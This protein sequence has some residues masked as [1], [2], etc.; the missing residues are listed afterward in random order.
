MTIESTSQPPKFCEYSCG[1]CDQVSHTSD[2]SDGLF[3]YSSNPENIAATIEETVKKVSETLSGQKWKTWKDLGVTG[4]IIFCEICKSIRH[5]KVVVADVTTLNFNLLFEI[6]FSLGLNKPVIPIRDTSYIRDK[7]VF[8]DLGLLDT[9]GYLDFQNSDELTKGICGNTNRPPSFSQY[10]T[11]NSEQPIYLIKSHIYTDG[12]IRLLSS[13][14]KSGLRFRTFDP[15]ETSRLSLHEAF[16]Q[17]CS[18]YGVVAHLVDPN[19][20]GAI[21]HNA[22]CAFLSGMAMATGKS[23]LMLQESE[24]SQPIDYRDVVKYYTQPSSIPDLLVPFVKSIVEKFQETRFIATSLPL[25]QLEKVDLGDLSAENEIQALGNY[26]V[27]T[28]QYNDAKRGHARLVVGRKGSGKTAIFYSVR[29][30]HKGF[31]HVTLDLKPE[32]HQFLKLREAVL[33]KLSPGLHQHVLT[34]VWTYLLLME[35]AYRIIRDDANYAYS[36]PKRRDAFEKILKAYGPIDVAEEADFSERLLKLVADILERHKELPNITTTADVTQL[37]YKQDVH[38]LAEIIA[39]YMN[40]ARKEDVWLL[41]DNLDKGWP[42]SLATTEDILILK[43]LLESTRKIQRQLEFHDIE[44]HS[45]VFIRNDIYQHLLL[46]PADRRKDTAVL[47][48]WNDKEVFKEILRRRIS[49]STSIEQPFDVIW[50]NFF[51]THVYGVESFSY[52]LDRTLMRPR[53]L[54]HFTRES[55]NMAINH[56]HTKVTQEDILKAEE[57]FSE[58]MLVDLNFE[59]KDVSPYYINLP[60]A[61]IGSKNV[62]P[63]DELVKIIAGVNVPKEKTDEAISLLLWFGFLGVYVNA[64]DERYSYQF[65]HDPKLMTAGINDFSYSIH[66]GF[67]KALG[68]Q[69]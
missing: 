69:D 42:V 11:L 14:K 18:S 51:D 37:I 67:R 2:F 29:T 48:E 27:P 64:D 39:D 34:A 4:Q 36:S 5:T 7:Q 16:K 10:P 52:I 61:F 60:Y 15:K 47:L 25:L 13:V 31:D 1:E 63:L 62:I 46:D 26:F 59:L 35:I 33:S 21:P 68:C 56:S 28:G 55:I 17:V 45:L 6:G 40:I 43:C 50:P 19:R 8:D 32:G 3:L 38:A 12:M 30:A 57:S 20:S 41:I 65:Q 23:T 58:D 54:L 66:P 53:E 49:S 9:L 24:V 22:R 44:F